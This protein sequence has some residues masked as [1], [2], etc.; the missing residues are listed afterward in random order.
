MGTPFQEQGPK[1]LTAGTLQSNN[2]EAG[3]PPAAWQPLRCSVSCHCPPLASSN[4]VLS[5]QQRST[6]FSAGPHQRLGSAPSRMLT[7]CFVR[8]PACPR[9][10]TMKT[11]FLPRSLGILLLD[12]LCCVLAAIPACSQ[13]DTEALP[14]SSSSQSSSA[15][16]FASWDT[17]FCPHAQIKRHSPHFHSFS[18][19]SCSQGQTDLCRGMTYS[20]GFLLVPLSSHTKKK[21]LCWYTAFLPQVTQTR[22]S[23]GT[24]FLSKNFLAL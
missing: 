5:C 12:S 19:L 11:L 4:A 2:L 22:S 15:T 7:T 21:S 1:P 8:C 20:W 16:Q 13:P 6:C 9:N 18:G 10:G 17:V 3:P 14:A 23:P 24:V